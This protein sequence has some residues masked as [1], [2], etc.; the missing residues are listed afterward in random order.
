M[1]KLY[2]IFILIFTPKTHEILL[3]LTNRFAS[4]CFNAVASCMMHVHLLLPYQ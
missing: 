1:L 2:C 3:Y 4:D